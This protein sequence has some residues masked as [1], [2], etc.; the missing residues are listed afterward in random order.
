MMMTI[1][2][3]KKLTPRAAESKRS[4]RFLNFVRL[5]S[6]EAAVAFRRSFVAASCFKKL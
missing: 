4:L 3:R 1:D 5:T 6:F 2:Y